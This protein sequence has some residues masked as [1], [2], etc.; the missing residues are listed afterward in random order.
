MRDRWWRPDR[1]SLLAV[2][3]FWVVGFV[4]LTLGAGPDR[5]AGRGRARLAT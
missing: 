3:V 5:R 2:A 4:N 1:G